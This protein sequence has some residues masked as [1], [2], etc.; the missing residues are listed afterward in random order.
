MDSGSLIFV[1]VADDLITLGN[2]MWVS[3]YDYPRS[4]LKKLRKIVE[5]LYQFVTTRIAE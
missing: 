3:Q 2:V 5:S 4:W 1:N